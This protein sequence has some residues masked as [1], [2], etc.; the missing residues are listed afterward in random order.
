MRIVEKPDGPYDLIVAGSGFGASFFL[1][2]FLQHA[3]PTQRVLVLERGQR[4]SHADQVAMGRNSDIN[5]D[6]TWRHQGRDDKW[7]NFTIA[8]GG[9]SNCWWGNALRLHPSDFSLNSSYGVGRDWP[10]SYNDLESY[11]SDVEQLMMISGPEEPTPWNRS[12]PLPLPPHRMPLPDRLLKEAY[13]DKHFV[14]T[15][16]R[17]SRDT[18]TRAKCCVNGVCNLCPIDSKFS[19]QNSFMSPYEDARVETV[20]GA[21][22]RAV[23][24]ES[25][26]ARGIV[27]KKNGKEYRVAADLVALGANGIF[28]PVILQRSGLDHPHLGRNLNEQYSAF[29]EAYLD[30]VD[31]FQGSTVVTGTNYLAYDGPF[32]RHQASALMET[33][34]MGRFRTDHG[35]WRQVMRFHL[36][37]EDLPQEKNQVVL[38][39]YEDDLPDVIFEDYS[40]YTLNTAAKIHDIAADIL[41]PLPVERIE[42]EPAAATGSHLHGT[43]I[44]GH[45]P[46]DSVLDAFQIHHTVRNLAVLGGGGFPSGSQTNPTVTVCA[47]AMRAADKLMAPSSP[48]A[49]R[50]GGGHS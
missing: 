12:R 46:A 37:L 3:M 42:I 43:T 26:L 17:P 7:W 18:D 25:G 39:K 34:N 35:R 13:P 31:H 27:Y 30:G 23:D 19:V 21:D 16:A 2:R 5:Q 22:V 10:L 50:P 15:T 14:V 20:L 38:N 32:R 28:N 36:K 33:W 44:M 8:F 11:Y 45:D 40:Q 41:S 4:H 9:G 49:S 1:Y 24:V 47:L 29:G 48:T 6:D